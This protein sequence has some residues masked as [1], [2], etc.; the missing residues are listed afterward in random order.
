VNPLMVPGGALV[1]VMALQLTAAAGMASAAEDVRPGVSP[2][3]IPEVQDEAVSGGGEVKTWKPGDPV[4]IVPDLRED[5]KPATSTAG[6]P[7]V[8][9]PIVRR[10]V[11]PRVLDGN[12]RGLQ[13]AGV[14]REGGP[15][16][17]V[18]DLREDD[19]KR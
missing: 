3:I 19:A 10:P 16:R 13:K 14:Y 12:L 8:S 15:V 4:R 11:A 6:Q 18:P 1:C 9:A 2:P 5:Q 7:G 17:V